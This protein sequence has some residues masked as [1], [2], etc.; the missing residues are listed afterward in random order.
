MGIKIELGDVLKQKKK[1]KYWLIKETH[2]TAQSLNKLIRNEACAI[3]FDTLERICIA[4]N[5]EPQD[6]IKIEKKKTNE[7]WFKILSTINS[8]YS[9]RLIFFSLFIFLW[10]F[11]NYIDIRVHVCYN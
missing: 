5:C 3:Y 10:Y 6:I 2:G 11:K 4:L 1:S 9:K 7:K 8:I